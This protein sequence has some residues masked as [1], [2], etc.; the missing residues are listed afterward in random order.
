MKPTR[1]GAALIEFAL[2][3]ALL[4]P[5]LGAVLQFGY[6]FL[7]VH[8][9]Q[10]AVDRGARLASSW[11]PDPVTGRPRADWREAVVQQ[12]MAGVD[13]LEAAQ[14][15]VDWEGRSVAVSLRGYRIRGWAGGWV[16]DGKPR[17]VYPY[18]GR[19]SGVPERDP[20]VFPGKD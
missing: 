14:V 16:I 7:M 4:A 18:R 10:D 2:A 17:A 20:G 12:V 8:Q 5:V 3:L 19:V 6:A 13:G 15:Q 11:P 9:I 1:K